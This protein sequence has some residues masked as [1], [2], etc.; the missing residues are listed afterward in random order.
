MA[1]TTEQR[2]DAR[3]SAEQRLVR[4]QD[5]VSCSVAFID[6]KLPGSMLKENYSII[7]AGVTQ[8]EDQV[9]NMTEPHGFQVGA[10]AMPNGVTNNLHMH[11]TAEVFMIFRGEW[12]FRWG[13]EG[14]DGEIVGREGD[15][16]SVP[17]WI[18]RGF[19]NIGADD[20]WIFTAL[21]QNDTGGVIWHPTIL[22]RAADEGLFLRRDSMLVDLSKGA[23]KPPEDE[24]I[25]PLRDEVIASMRRYSVE[26][27]LGRVT[28]YSERRFSDRSLLQAVL[29]GHAAALAPVIGYGMTEDRNAEAKVMNPHGFSVEWL[30]IEAGQSVGPFKL[31][32][33]QV[34]VVKT[35]SVEVTLGEGAEASRATAAANDVFSAPADVS[36]TLTAVGGEP[37][38]MVLV[39][40]GD[41]RARIAWSADIVA[42]AA[43]AG[44]GLDPNGYVGPADCLPPAE[45]AEA[46]E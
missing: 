4:R 17:T 19:T 22:R 28:P 8:S 20:G 5:M 41:G 3:V 39:T 27:M 6:C 11:Y 15:I 10:A 1:T 2:T 36:R 18:F 24:L 26:D 30:R 44:F 37:V 43:E 42:R 29:P 32:R 25:Q 7:G 35:G 31:D 16:L 33:K 23:V 45:L 13:P 21:G 12:V 38:E 40:S 34:L 9:V 46:A 14:K